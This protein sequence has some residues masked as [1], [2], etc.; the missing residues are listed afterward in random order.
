MRVYI[1]GPYT[2]GDVAQNVVLA[3]R[4]GDYVADKGHIPF[5]PH[6]SHFWHMI[7]PRPYEYWIEYDLRWLELCDIMIRIEGESAGAEKEEAWAKRLGRR[8]VFVKGM[9]G[10]SLTKIDQALPPL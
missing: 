1:A 7:T 10:K 4:I 3:I 2:K 5:I 9:D 6:L 8:I